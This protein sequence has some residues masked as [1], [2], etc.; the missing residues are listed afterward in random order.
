MRT[1]TVL[2]TMLTLSCSS[3]AGPSAEV[4]VPEPQ[5]AADGLT[6]S[7]PTGSPL[8][9]AVFERRWAEEGLFIWGRCTDAPRCPQVPP[10]GTVRVPVEE[11]SGYF[12]GAREARVY[13]WRLVASKNGYEVTDFRTAI[14]PF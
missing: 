7:N 2:L 10:R 9:Y 3:P 5:S 8:Y 14:V 4:P 12:P 6:L 1:A 13:F 11:I